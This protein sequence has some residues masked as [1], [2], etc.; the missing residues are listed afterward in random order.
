M[1]QTEHLRSERADGSVQ[2]AKIGTG[3]IFGAAVC[4]HF[5]LD[6][7]KVEAGMLVHTGADEIFGLT[8]RISL[9]GDDIAAIGEIMRAAG[10]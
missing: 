1:S 9:T 4:K 6:P 10:K 3:L 8:L 7:M 2:K 5:A